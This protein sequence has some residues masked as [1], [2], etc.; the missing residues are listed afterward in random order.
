MMN[1]YFL[2]ILMNI[3]R[4]IRVVEEVTGTRGN[5]LDNGQIAKD[6]R[7]V[8]VEFGQFREQ[9]EDGNVTYN[10]RAGDVE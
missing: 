6:A 3:L 8:E 1:N 9:S 4:D 2:F 7:V 10:T 5:F